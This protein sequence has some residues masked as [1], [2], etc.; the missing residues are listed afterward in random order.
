L[1]NGLETGL[2]MAAVTWGLV[3]AA[4]P[5]PTA[6]YGLGVLCGIMPAVRPELAALALPLL[7]QRLWS[8]WAH[9]Q[10]DKLPM[11]AGIVLLFL[12]WSLVWM[13]PLGLATGLPDPSTIET[14][15][16][17]LA[18]GALDIRTKIKWMIAGLLVFGSQVGLLGV[19][20][21]GLFNRRE[22]IPVLCFASAVVLSYGL[23]FPGALAHYESR[24]L[25]PLLPVLIFGLVLMMSSARRVTQVAGTGLL[26][27]L[28][29]Q[30]VLMSHHPFAMW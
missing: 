29:G 6:G 3:L 5:S 18:E 27:R 14:K 7:T 12:T 17:F 21:I 4:M 22:G 30:T 16:L 26:A 13:V 10:Q 8:T 28:L 24:Y 1:I 11:S 20:I 25:Y 15:R 19:A 23:L 2:A 9:Q